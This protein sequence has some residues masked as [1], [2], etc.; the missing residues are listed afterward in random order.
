V[1]PV[2]QPSDGEPAAWARFAHEAWAQQMPVLDVWRYGTTDEATLRYLA[3]NPPGA[4][5]SL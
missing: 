2:A 3:A 5:P 1:V 4:E